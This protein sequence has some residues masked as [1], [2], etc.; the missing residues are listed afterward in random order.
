VGQ[1]RRQVSQ[2]MHSDISMRNAGSF[3]FGLRSCDRTRSV[4]VPAGI[5]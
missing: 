3:H 2:L 4:R 5:A 1:W